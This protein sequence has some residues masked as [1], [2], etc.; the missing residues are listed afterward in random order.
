MA[1]EGPDT[2]DD[3]AEFEYLPPCAGC[4]HWEELHES[5]RAGGEHC[6]AKGCKCTRYVAMPPAPEGEANG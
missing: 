2:G 1:S 4:R 6:H 3:R 5:D